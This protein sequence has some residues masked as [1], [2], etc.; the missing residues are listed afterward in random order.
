[1]VV[2][3]ALNALQGD[4]LLL[5]LGQRDGEDKIW[6]IDGGPGA[7]PALGGDDAP[8]EVARVTPIPDVVLPHLEA[9]RR[10]PPPHVI[11]LGVC[12]HIDDDH[13]E[14]MR[15]LVRR[16]AAL[17]PNPSDQII[18]RRFWFNSLS[19][20]LA[21]SDGGALAP[22]SLGRT[23]ADAFRATGRIA[24]G[25]VAQAIGGAPAPRGTP[26][27]VAQSINQGID[28]ESDLRT[29]KLA[30]NLPFGGPVTADGRPLRIDGAV[31]TLLGPRPERLARLRAEWQAALEKPTAASRD[32]AVGRLAARVIRPDT[33]YPNLSSIVM[34][35]E[36][37]GRRLLLT[38]DALGDDVVEAWRD[39]LGKGAAVCPVDVLKL[40]HHGSIRN[41]S[42]AFL[43]TFPA[44]HYVFSGNGAHDNPDAATIEM[45]VESAQGAGREI[46]LHFT[47]AG[48]VWKAPQ[49]VKKTGATAESLDA[50]LAALKTAY[51]TGWA[52]KFRDENACAVSIPLPPK[53]GTPAV[54]DIAPVAV[55]PAEA[56]PKKP[57]PGKKTAPSDAANPATPKKPRTRKKAPPA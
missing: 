29:A 13:I 21:G 57:R 22:Q 24:A 50:Y 56:E 54:A 12:T 45:V 7:G 44:D 3:E 37:D 14:G 38:G 26:Q 53:A 46:T 4:C 49:T 25:G 23:I 28:L 20:V 30:G 40:P 15:R 8:K 10:V 43:A 34:L 1:M 39:D 27:A 19:A 51:P 48:I 6:M 52:E 36:V 41:V 42:K 35:V 9:V 31:V 18:F 16:M 2:F 32:G 17:T 5:R 55:P 33:S 47:N 11:S